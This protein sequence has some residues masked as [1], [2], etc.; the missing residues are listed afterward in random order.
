[1]GQE[2]QLKMEIQV[3]HHEAIEN[4]AN[5][6]QYDYMLE[7]LKLV[8]DEQNELEAEGEEQIDEI[9]MLKEIEKELKN[10]TEHGNDEEGIVLEVEG[11]G[12]QG[13]K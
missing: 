6:E 8:S 4:Q 12:N 3:L 11:E 9:E 10:I 7:K 5:I 1:M 13:K 2:E